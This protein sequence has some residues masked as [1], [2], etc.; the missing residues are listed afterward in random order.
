MIAFSLLVLYLTFVYFEPNLFFPVLGELHAARIVGVLALVMAA[1]GGG[2]PGK[3][4]QN[5]LFV[6]LFCIVLLSSVVAK[7]PSGESGSLAV[8]YYLR[9]IALYFLIT[10]VLLSRQYIIAFCY[11][12]LA[13]GFVVSFVSLLTARAGIESLKGGNVY[14]LVNYFGGIGDDPNEFGVLLVALLPLPIVLLRGEQSRSMRL[15]LGI[16]ALIFMLC[17]TRTRS[18]GAFIGLLTALALV[19]WSHRRNLGIFVFGIGLAVFTFFHTHEGYWVRIATLQSRESISAEASANY[20]LLQIGYASRLM[21]LYPL[22]GV[23]PGNFVR[24]K[25]AFLGLDGKRAYQAAHNSYLVVGAEVGILGMLIFIL[26]III[27]IRNAYAYGSYF[28]SKA[29]DV[30]LDNISTGVSAGLAGLAVTIFFLSEQYNAIIYQW[31]GLSVALKNL[32]Q[33]GQM[34]SEVHLRGGRE[35]TEDAR[36]DWQGAFSDP[37]S[38]ASPKMN[39]PPG[40]RPSVPG[41]R[42]S[43]WKGNK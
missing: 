21:K 8:S 7:V 29:H 22:T 38:L 14:R 1:L 4:A 17:I 2:R 42:T 33:R 31:I 35:G 27:S 12:S 36:R 24:A 20:R 40:H 6:C 43:Q 41:P 25:V 5:I 30:I 18:R 39:F 9:G 16:M 11:T 23:G 13:L 19:M 34:M 3:S 28:R 15:L 32:A 26:L 37:P 10:M